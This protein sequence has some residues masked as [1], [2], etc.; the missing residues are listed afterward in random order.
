MENK[1]F[2]FAERFKAPQGEGLFAGTVMA[3]A[4]LVGCSVGKGVCTMC[5]TDYSETRR[6]LG[7]GLFTADEILDWAEDCQHLCL[8]G[9]EPLDRD[10]RPILAAAFLR[11]VM[12]HIETSGTRNPSWLRRASASWN[13]VFDDG[14]IL[15]MGDRLWVTVSPK[16][17]Y[18]EDMV[19]SADEVKVINGGLGDGPGWP[20]L[21]DAVCWANMGKLVYL[22][23]ANAIREISFENL[24]SC[25]SAVLSNPNLRIS[26]QMHKF[27]K[28]R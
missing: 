22:Q 21:S 25:I 15:H 13:V 16:P 6:E 20:T 26:V 23:P 9:G 19:V 24:Q 18:L 2:P 4:R 8:T 12:V 11:G 5:D 14:S 7:G 17:G 3:F 10:V 28:T 27:W 1:T